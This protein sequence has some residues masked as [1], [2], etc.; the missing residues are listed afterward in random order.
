MVV[1]MAGGAIAWDVIRQGRMQKCRDV[2]KMIVL[3]VT[4]G[5][6]VLQHKL[7]GSQPYTIKYIYV[8]FDVM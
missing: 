1:V 5:V 8:Q 7:N 2:I 6:Y 3:S 4:R